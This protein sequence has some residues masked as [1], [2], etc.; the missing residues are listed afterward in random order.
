MALRG[1]LLTFVTAMCMV[2]W[3][4]CGENGIDPDMCASSDSVF[5]GETLRDWKSFA[6]HVALVRV[7]STRQEKRGAYERPVLRVE[8]LRT[9]WSARE[10]PPLRDSGD[11]HSPG[12]MLDGREYA[13]PL[14]QVD[15]DGTPVW[16]PLTC[17]S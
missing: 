7:A 15:D 3:A 14:V 16:T 9:Y 12:Y 6:D 17:D 4:G 10:A 2:A 11:L 1:G 13:L 8:V 5:A